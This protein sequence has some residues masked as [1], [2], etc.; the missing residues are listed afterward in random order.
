MPNLH[1]NALGLVLGMAAVPAVSADVLDLLQAQVADRSGGV[2]SAGLDESLSGI[3]S[4]VRFGEPGS[5]SWW[6]GGVGA[7]EFGIT[8]LAGLRGGVEW[9]V[10]TDFSLGLQGDLGWAATE[11]EAGGLLAGLAPLLRWHFLNRD[12]WTLFAELGVGA[13]WT[14]VRIPEGGTRFNFTPQAAVG[15]SWDIGDDWRLRA[16]AG[17]YHMS[18]ARTSNNNPGLDAFA[19]TFGVMRTF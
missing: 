10:A 14:T 1:P 9:F 4:P 18:N 5:G 2:E 16:T 7:A 8:H 15:V 3:A 13:A 6:I 19:I 11:G 17:W 12:T